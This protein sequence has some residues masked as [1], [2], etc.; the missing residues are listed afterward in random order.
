M[1]GLQIAVLAGPSVHLPI[2]VDRTAGDGHERASDRVAVRGI[3]DVGNGGGLLDGVEGGVN[4]YNEIDKHAAQWQRELIAD[5]LIS[6][7]TVDERSIEDVLPTEL[8]GYERCHFFSG[9]GVWD[10]ALNLAGWDR[11]NT[12]TGSCPCQPF[13]AAGKRGG[14]DDERHLWPAWFHL[15]EQCRP[16]FIFGEQV[17]SK[18]GTSWLDLVHSDLEG[19]GYTVGTVD[20]PA[21]GFGAPHRRQRLYFVAYAG[22]DERLRRDGLRYSNGSDAG[23]PE[24]NE[25]ERLERVGA[26]DDLADGSTSN[27]LAHAEHA[28]NGELGDTDGPRSQRRQLRSGSGASECVTRSAGLTNGYWRNAEWI[29][30]T[31]GKYRPVEPSIFPLAYERSPGRV[32]CL[33]G[34]GNA[35][36]AVQAAEFVKAF[37]EILEEEGR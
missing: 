11:P 5:G 3:A 31:D 25:R 26:V 17:S 21:A 32:G 23:T 2:E 1:S 22:R 9:I 29:Y 12:W 14:T 20:I 30:C 37:K 4:F 8:A 35:I 34:A 10:Y 28:G 18:D 13:S 36:V 24:A 19:I 27:E 16:D 15:I 33:R 7:G 6:N